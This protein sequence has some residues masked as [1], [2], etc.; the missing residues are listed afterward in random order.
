MVKKLLKYEFMDYFKKMIPITA[1][2]LGIAATIRFLYFFE[3][4]TSVFGITSG[5]MIFALVGGSVASIVLIL[6]FG[7]RRF[8][9]NLFSN[10]GYLSMTL[11]VTPTQHIFAKAVAATVVMIYDLIIIVAAVMTA[12]AGE[13]C[14]EIIKAGWYLWKQAFG[15]FGANQIAYLCYFAVI[16]ILKIANTFMLF[17]TCLT[18]G[19]RAKKAKVGLAVGVFFI[20]YFSVQFIS[21]VILIL[22]TFL[23]WEFFDE[24]ARIIQHNLI[25]SIHIIMLGTIILQVVYFIIT[26]VIMRHIMKKKLNLE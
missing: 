23:G 10:E 21:T 4:D 13:V 18:I 24:L 15:Y 7:I 11:P 2:L 16:V 19:Q 12:T 1:I 6:V 17:Y 9:S 8:Y 22:T 26:Y 25:P 3:T 5:S 20:Y 14:T